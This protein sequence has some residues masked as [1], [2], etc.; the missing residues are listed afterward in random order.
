M[1]GRR[2]EDNGGC[3]P[4]QREQLL[5]EELKEAGGGRKT[6][7]LSTITKGS[8]IEGGNR[9]KKSVHR[10]KRS[11]YWLLKFRER[12]NANEVVQR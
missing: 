10:G 12:R 9:E 8:S 2:E 1:R 4:K 5:G 11:G 3:R 7:M 6:P